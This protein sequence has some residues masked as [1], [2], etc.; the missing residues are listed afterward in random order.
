MTMSAAM[1][2]LEDNTKYCGLSI[3]PPG[4]IK[5]GEVVF[6]TGMSGYQEILTDPSYCGQIMVF[7]YPELGNTAV[8]YE[9]DE[10]IMPYT[11]AVI[12]NNICFSIN[13]WRSKVSFIEYC[14]NNKIILLY[15]IDTRNLIKK[16]RSKG[17]VNGLIFTSSA[18]D[19]LQQNHQILS[20]LDIPSMEGLN[21][22][23]HVS[24][25]MPYQWNYKSKNNW[26]NYISEKKIEIQKYYKIIA[27]DFGIKANILRRFNDKGCSII[28]LPISTSYEEILAYK[29]DGI[30]LSNGP[31]D[32]SIVNNGIKTVIHLLS[33]EKMIP[34]FGICMGHQ[35]LSLAI[36]SLTFKLKFGH[37][38]LNH[39]AGLTKR[40]EVTS[41]NHGFAVQPESINNDWIKITHFNLNDQTIAGIC[42]RSKPIFSIQYHPEAGPGPHDSDYLFDHFLKIVYIFKKNRVYKTS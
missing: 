20:L 3:N 10:S 6:N 29:A 18:T 16:I 8:N 31:G 40:M 12:V 33:I 28:V 17:S 22:V 30:F 21:L 32:P 34:M 35:I 9:D 38:G 36:G 11:Q 19:V 4:L 26:Y 14:L 23:K 5:K 27:L 13:N 7:S 1:L 41:Q 2:V 39:P 42:H 37:H 15:G 24:T 25:K